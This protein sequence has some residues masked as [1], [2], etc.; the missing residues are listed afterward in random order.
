MDLI[1]FSNEHF[2]QNKLLVFPKHNTTNGIVSVFVPEGRFLEQKNRHEAKKIAELLEQVSWSESV[3]V[4]AFSEEQL[5]CIWKECSEKVRFELEKQEQN[6]QGFFLSLENVQGDEADQLFISLGYAKNEEEK[7]MLRM[8]AL[9]HSGGQ[10][11]LNVLLTRARKKIYFIHSINAE[12][13]PITENIGINYLR[14][15]LYF[16]EKIKIDSVNN[17]LPFGLKI[18]ENDSNKIESKQVYSQISDAKELLSCYRSLKNRGWK[19]V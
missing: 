1:A 16:L 7:L 2:Y 3:G 5:Q 6:G 4:V 18:T 12:T 9:T 17:T 13:I 19:W 8:G 15:W 14:K 10:K 11:R